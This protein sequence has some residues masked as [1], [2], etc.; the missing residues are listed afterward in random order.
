M[1]SKELCD[2]IRGSG[3]LR[4]MHNRWKA[5]EFVL[6]V[7]GIVVGA[8]GQGKLSDID[9]ALNMSARGFTWVTALDGDELE[10]EMEIK[11]GDVSLIEEGPDLES[12]DFSTLDSML[13]WAIGHSD[14]EKLKGA[15]QEIQRLTPK[16][17]EKRRVDIKVCE[18]DHWLDHCLKLAGSLAADLFTVYWRPEL[19][20][21]AIKDLQNS[22]LSTEERQLA[23]QELLVLVE[24][25]DNAI[26]VF[27]AL[28]EVL[29]ASISALLDLLV[30][31]LS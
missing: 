15:A 3:R 16:E 14:P 17:L 31:T 23:L 25:I 11:A 21:I 29:L 4:S 5:L 27:S 13:Q 8:S 12:G 10:R 18:P 6:I 28:Y 24:P 9:G 7:I 22:S 26:G 1:S 30:R 20:K 2:V 19:M